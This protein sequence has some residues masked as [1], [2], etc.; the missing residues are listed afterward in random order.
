MDFAGVGGGGGGV[1]RHNANVDLMSWYMEIPPISRLYLT[2]AFLTTAACAVDLISPFSLYFSWE[3]VYQGQIWR[4]LTSYLFFGVFSVDF[5][6]HMYFLVR[7]SRLLEEGDFRGRPA[8]YIW[9]LLFGILNISTMASYYQVNFLGSA[10][11]FMMAYV[12]GRRNEDV[13]MSFLGFLQ[14]N[15][16]YLPWVML[17][18]SILIGNAVVMDVIGICVGHLY[19]FLEF[20]YPVMASIRN[21]PI[22]RIMEPPALLHLICGTHDNVLPGRPHHE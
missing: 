5:L 9:M 21:W 22:K 15:A 13:K 19:Y 3:L 14:F 16:P 17:T 1:M 4:L 18:F 20:V 11:T 2:G 12:W 8:H 7:Y 10:L 6:F